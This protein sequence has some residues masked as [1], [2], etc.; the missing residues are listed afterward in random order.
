VTRSLRANAPI[1]FLDARGLS[2]F[3]RYHAVEFGPALSRNADEG[4][5]GRFEA[6][7]GS[8]GLAI[9]TGGVIVANTNDMEKGLDR[10]L[11]T[12]ATYYVITYQAPTHDKA[13]YRKISVD[14]REKGFKVRA[15]RGY[16]SQATRR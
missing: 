8:T 11:D 5:F 3:N 16:F 4:P 2:G 10:L 6:A 9:D 14:V 15:R 7:E 1:H 13:G 12:M